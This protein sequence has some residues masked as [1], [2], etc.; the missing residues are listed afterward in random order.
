VVVV[1]MMLTSMML[2]QLHQQV[3]K[4]VAVNAVIVGEVQQLLHVIDK[5]RL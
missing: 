3:L 1:E 5:R 4:F 2:H